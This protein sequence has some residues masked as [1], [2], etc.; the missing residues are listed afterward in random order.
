M[1]TYEEFKISCID[2]WETNFHIYGKDIIPLANFKLAEKWHN[3]G[4]LTENSNAL[5]NNILDR[6]KMYLHTTG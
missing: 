3:A 6:L 4:M 2:G 5:M 1:S